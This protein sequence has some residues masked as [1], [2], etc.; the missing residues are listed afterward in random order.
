MG[1]E[2]SEEVWQAEKK[3]CWGFGRALANEER[4]KGKI[5]GGKSV[6]WAFNIFMEG[7]F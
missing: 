3:R 1:D 6:C 7:T 2:K 4:R 5:K